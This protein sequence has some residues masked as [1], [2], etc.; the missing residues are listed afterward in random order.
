[1]DP[2]ERIVY[3]FGTVDVSQADE[4][5]DKRIKLRLNVYPFHDGL[6]TYIDALG[7]TYAEAVAT[8]QRK[9][10]AEISTILP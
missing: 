7:D 2:I 4:G 8:L 6:P 3:Q 5:I 9:I 1:M 10:K